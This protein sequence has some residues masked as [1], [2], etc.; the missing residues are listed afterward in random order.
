MGV[1]IITADRHHALV[2]QSSDRPQASAPLVYETFPVIERAHAQ[3]PMPDQNFLKC[4]DVQVHNG[5][6]P[7]QGPATGCKHP[8]SGREEC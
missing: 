3:R 4:E 1:E 8:P 6:L 2:M 5:V 7:G